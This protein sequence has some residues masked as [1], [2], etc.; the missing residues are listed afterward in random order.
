MEMSITMDVKMAYREEYLSGMLNLHK[1]F[2]CELNK[3]PYDS[4]I[5]IDNYMRQSEIRAKMDVGNW[6]ALN[7]GCKQLIN[8]TIKPKETNNVQI[9]D[10]S[11]HWIATI[12]VLLQWKY[13]LSSKM[14]SEAIP[15][16]KLFAM[17]NPLHE[18]NEFQAVNK[19]YTQYFK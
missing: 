4:F 2:F 15:S 17:F 11:L 9:D 8:D 18:I 14:I 16:E 5:L 10:I 13:C 12:Y 6:S 1:M 19:L 3:L 7:K